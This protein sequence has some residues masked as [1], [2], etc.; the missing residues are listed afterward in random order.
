M[1]GHWQKINLDEYLVNLRDYYSNCEKPS[2]R[3]A[4]KV[5]ELTQEEKDY[6]NANIN[7]QGIT[8]F[9]KE[10]LIISLLSLPGKFNF[11]R[12]LIVS[13]NIELEVNNFLD[14]KTTFICLLKQ[15]ISTSDEFYS[16]GHLFLELYK[17]GYES[18]ECD[19]VFL[20]EIYKDLPTKNSLAV[21]CIARFA[22][23]LNDHK[24][25]DKAFRNDRVLFSIISFKMKKP[26]GFNYPNLLGVANNAIQHYR[27]HG[28]ILI[29]SMYHYEVYNDIIERDKKKVFQGKQKDFEKYKP[30]QDKEFVEIVMHLFPE[31]KAS[32]KL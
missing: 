14:G 9:N 26:V 12:H 1:I 16:A 23:L 19:E 8:S 17:R 29:K 3:L 2:F 15:L 10:C 22:F 25:F 27:D 13:G 11:V 20:R 24:T 32:A 7:L 18:K 30:I 21:W 28:D 31:L 6:V 5:Q 4:H